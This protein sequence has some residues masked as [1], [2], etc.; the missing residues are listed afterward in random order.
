MKIGC[1]FFKNKM[2]KNCVEKHLLSQQ[3]L[4]FFGLFD[5]PVA[6]H[7]CGHFLDA[8]QRERRLGKRFHGD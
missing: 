8:L 4:F 7:K 6:A 2:R 3:M 5:P 1:V